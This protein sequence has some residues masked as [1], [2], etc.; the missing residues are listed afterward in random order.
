MLEAFRGLV[1][2]V[3]CGGALR[4]ISFHLFACLLAC[5]FDADADAL[6][7]QQYVLKYTRMILTH[8]FSPSIYLIHQSTTRKPQ[9]KLPTKHNGA[10]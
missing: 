7:C 2:G 4:M 10:P 8:E 9:V 3:V 5:C 1:E 6:V